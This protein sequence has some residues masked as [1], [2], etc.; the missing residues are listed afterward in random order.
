MLAKAPSASTLFLGDLAALRAP[1][2]EFVY[3]WA[4]GIHVQAR[5]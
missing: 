5:L 3:F 2:E 1:L 4:D